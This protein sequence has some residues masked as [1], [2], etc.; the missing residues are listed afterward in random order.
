MIPGQS[1]REVS[2]LFSYD[3]VQNIHA[4]IDDN[5]EIDEMHEDNNHAY[6]LLFHNKREAGFTLQTLR[7]DK[8]ITLTPLTSPDGSFAGG[9]NVAINVLGDAFTYKNVI[10]QLWHGAVGPAGRLIATLG[11]PRVGGSVTSQT[12][13]RVTAYWEVKNPRLYGQQELHAVILQSGFDTEPANIISHVSQTVTVACY[14]EVDACGECG[15]RGESCAGCDGVPHSGAIVDM[16][17]VCG[18]DDSTCCVPLPAQAKLV[19]IRLRGANSDDASA[20]MVWRVKVG[21][22]VVWENLLDWDV[23]IKA[24][25][26]DARDNN[27]AFE[28][29]ALRDHGQ[30]LAGMGGTPSDQDVNAFIQVS[31]SPFACVCL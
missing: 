1:K 21:D 31:P 7:L 5:S 6:A 23:E 12:R 26:P 18:G 28:L 2:F 22:M 15:G 10:V 11:L 29:S 25:L 16:C 4:T 13:Y 17:G 30:A 20:A 24:G 19:H 8:R 14:G 27:K 3:G 9:Y